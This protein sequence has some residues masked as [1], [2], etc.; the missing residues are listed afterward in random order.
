MM[1]TAPEE[2]AS[3]RDE[4]PLPD[5]DMLS[6]LADGVSG[7]LEDTQSSHTVFETLPDRVSGPLKNTQS[8]HP[9]WRMFEKH[10]QT[11]TL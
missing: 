6:S 3:P 11:H 2:R 4:Y 1:T 7:P 5:F 8:S 10:S 9:Q